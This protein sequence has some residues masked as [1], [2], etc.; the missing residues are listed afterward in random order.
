MNT[1]SPT[2][3]SLRKR[4]TQ[5]A[6]ATIAILP[7]QASRFPAIDIIRGAIMLIMALDHVR[8]FLHIS[9]LADEPTN[10]VTTTPVL[11]FTR[12]ITH[13]CAPAFIFLSGIS[14]YISGQKKTKRELSAFLIKRGLWMIVVELVF[15]SFSW[16]FDVTY[17]GFFL[18]VIWAIGWSMMILGLMVRTS[19]TVIAVV[20]SIIFFG[21][22]ILDYIHLPQQGITSVLWKVFLTSKV[23]FFVL[24][25]ARS[26]LLVYPILPWAAI[27]MLGYVTGQLY[28][29][30]FDD[31]QRK[32]LL[33]RTG[34]GL[35]ALFIVL[36]LINQYGDP[37]Q[38]SQQKNLTFSLLSF[39][40]VTK[41]PVSLQYSCMTLGTVLIM[42]SVLKNRSNKA[43]KFL[44][45]FGKVPFFYY[46]FH[47]Y[48][49]HIITAF[50][51]FANGHSWNEIKDAGSFILFRPSWFGVNLTTVYIVWIS[52]ILILYFPCRWFAGY[53]AE[54]KGW[55]LSYI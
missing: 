45:V 44:T 4:I 21:H 30:K 1:Y 51:F 10:L 52:V 16:S 27:M 50:L 17:S 38:W 26:I 55:W 23:D 25:N 22:N 33:L 43:T 11:F 9:S 12:W 14:A 47:F 28:T 19:L 34:I 3:F 6:S 39:L 29:K 31:K 40:N 48:L 35:V 54:N 53:K 46:V 42:L 32:K 2:S 49:I 5:P 41:Y 15:I 20:G 36:R 7:A 24:G 13:F 8:H 18:Q 37:H